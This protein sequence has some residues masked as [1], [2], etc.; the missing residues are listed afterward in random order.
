MFF[1]KPKKT[2][3][4]V[5][6]TFLTIIEDL[7]QIIVDQVVESNMLDDHRLRIKAQ[8]EAVDLEIHQARGIAKRLNVLVGGD[9]FS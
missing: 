9:D 8:I 5:M 6:Q 4:T 7:D 2:V 1:K 3:S